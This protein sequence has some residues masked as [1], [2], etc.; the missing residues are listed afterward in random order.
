M[1]N[2]NCLDDYT[3]ELKMSLNWKDTEQ[4][5]KM[6]RRKPG[7]MDERSKAAGSRKSSVKNSDTRVCVGSNPTTVGKRFEHDKTEP[8]AGKF[9]HTET[10]IQDD[11]PK[12]KQTKDSQRHP[13]LI[14]GRFKSAQKRRYQAKTCGTRK[15]A[16]VWTKTFWNG[17]HKPF[18]RLHLG[19]EKVTQWKGHKSKEKMCRRKPGRMAERS[20][21]PGSRKSAVENSGTRVC[22]WV[23]IPPLGKR[24]KHDKP[25]PSADKFCHTE[26]WIQDDSSKQTK[27]K[28][29][30]RHWVVD[31][32]AV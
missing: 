14:A 5:E 18:S 25:E 9:C 13:W 16:W 24:F 7:R 23:P 20:K 11:S 28:D 27:T 17:W 8:S 12:Q 10:L 21:A 32:R 3:S 30:Q 19:I 1:D 4:K 29:S 31:S 15:Y 26:T 6:C 22:A 2:T